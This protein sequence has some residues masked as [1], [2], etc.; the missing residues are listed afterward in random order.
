MNVHKEQDYTLMMRA[1]SVLV[2]VLDVQCHA[3]GE[4]LC[5]VV[6]SVDIGVCLIEL[7][8]PVVHFYFSTLMVLILLVVILCQF[9]Q[10]FNPKPFFTYVFTVFSRH[11]G[12]VFC[13]MRVHF[14]KLLNEYGKNEHIPV[15]LENDTPNFYLN[16]EM[17]SEETRSVRDAEQYFEKESQ[18]RETGMAE[19][20]ACKSNNQ[21][22]IGDDVE[23]VEESCADA[24]TGSEEDE[25]LEPEKFPH[26]K[27]TR[28]S[29]LQ[30]RGFV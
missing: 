24:Q 23:P 26:L 10:P 16:R 12:V 15:C 3:S 14:E 8:V 6:I 13:E 18:R 2:S 22:N 17:K 20:I 9:I 30:R 28:R 29:R 7:S 4:V 25:S 27:R 21:L 1:L 19:R 11:L 5:S